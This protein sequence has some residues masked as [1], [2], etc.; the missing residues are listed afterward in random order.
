MNSFSSTL[1]EL[2]NFSKIHNGRQ[3]NHAPDTTPDD[4]NDASGTVFEQM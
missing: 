1:K 4:R 2:L 3:E